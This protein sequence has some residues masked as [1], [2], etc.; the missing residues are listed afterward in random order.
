VSQ[1]AARTG[2]WTGTSLEP[3]QLQRPKLAE[4]GTTAFETES[5]ENCRSLGIDSPGLFHPVSLVQIRPAVLPVADM[6][7]NR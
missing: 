1:E 2:T 4:S 7:T 6:L 3:G 5:V